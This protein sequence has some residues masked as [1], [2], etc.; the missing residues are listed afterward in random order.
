[1]AQIC[2]Q[3]S[4]LPSI[5]E[6][7]DM[8]VDSDPESAW[9]FDIEDTQWLELFRPFTAVRTLRICF[10]LQPPILVALQELTGETATEVLPA[11]DSLYLEENYLEVDQPSVS[12]QQA[13]KP[14]LAARQYSDR[15][16]A[17]HL[18]ERFGGLELE[19]SELK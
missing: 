5:V 1:M 6:Q 18:W 9:Q 12:E 2:N 16:V 15:P 3:L 7:L 10:E 14:F 13:I 11:L 8:E 17:V 4:L 19:G